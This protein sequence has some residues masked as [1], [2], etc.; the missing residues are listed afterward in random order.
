[1]KYFFTLFFIN[2]VLLLPSSIFG[3]SNNISLGNPNEKTLERL[4]ILTGTPLPFHASMKPYP[5]KDAVQYV[6]NLL[7]STT[8]SKNPSS[9]YQL[10]TINQ[11]IP[12]GQQTT[13]IRR[14]FRDYN[15]WIEPAVAKRNGEG[16][17]SINYELSEKPLLKWF[18]RSPAN[19]YEAN[20]EYY[21]LRVNPV[22][23]FQ[24]SKGAEGKE[25]LYENQRG[26]EIRGGLDG[27]VF[28][29]SRIMENQAAFPEYV[30]GFV[31]KF[32]ALPGN[33][34]YKGFSSQFFNITGA[35]DY[36]NAEGTVAFNATRH[37]GLQFGHGRNAI[38]NGYRSLLLSGFAQNYLH[39]KVNWEIGP[40]RYQNLFAELSALSSNAPSS[41]KLIPKKYMALHYLSIRPVNNLTLG[42]F[43]ATIFNRE[44]ET[45][46]F[47]LHYLNPVILYRSVEHFLKSPDNVLIGANLQWNLFRRVQ[48]YGQL[49]FDEFKFKEFFFDEPGW[50]AK[51]IGLQ[52][53]IKY[54][55]ALGVEN[56]DLQLEYNAVRPYTYSHYDSV[57]PSYSHYNQALAHPLGS[58]FREILFLLRYQPTHKWTVETRVFRM[59]TGDDPAGQNWGS[60]ILLP[61]TSRVKEYGN[62]IGQGIHAT[63]TLLGLDICY[64]LRHNLFLDVHYF[65]RKKNS[66]LPSLSSNES[67]FGMGVRLNI[68]RGRME[69]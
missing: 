69:F 39:G 56:L 54:I 60:N 45:G 66:D 15:E 47:E 12:S 37:I 58:N 48:L 30:D 33:G 1:M 9:G 24:V 8:Y 2:T 3:Q 42:L 19:Y 27:K 36:L 67:Y 7:D 20:G 44:G 18:Y 26:L 4:E 52:S 11:F 59:K 41:S 25:W 57:G 21:Y 49:L 32:S 46:Q 43:E 23:N 51:K 29:W 55:N 35:Y 17:Y 65:L 10:T 5:A 68:E 50:W 64:E 28:F 16:P 31:R 6:S 38:G 53:G 14:I 34:L 63:T 40:V 61:N 13:K 62:E 22:L